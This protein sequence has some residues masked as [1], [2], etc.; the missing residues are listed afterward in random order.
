[1]AESVNSVDVVRDWDKMYKVFQNICIYS[2]LVTTKSSGLTTKE[3]EQFLTKFCETFAN[4]SITKNYSTLVQMGLYDEEK[5]LEDNTT[6][7]Q[8]WFFDQLETRHAIK[9]TNVAG[10][11]IGNIAN[12]FF[13]SENFWNLVT[14][15]MAAWVRGD[16]VITISETETGYVKDLTHEIVIDLSTYE[17]ACAVFGMTG[18]IEN[19]SEYN[20][21]QTALDQFTA[22]MVDSSKYIVN[23]F[24]SPDYEKCVFSSNSYFACIPVN[25]NDIPL[26]KNVDR[27]D[28]IY[29]EN[30]KVY[31]HTRMRVLKLQI[32]GVTRYNR[33]TNGSVDVV[34]AG[35]QLTGSN[36]LPFVEN[37][38]YN[39][40]Q[41]IQ[42]NIADLFL[43]KMQITKNDFPNDLISEPLTN[44]LKRCSGYDTGVIVIGVGGTDFDT[45]TEIKVFQLEYATL[46]LTLIKNDDGTFTITSDDG[47]YITQ[48]NITVDRTKTAPYS[49]GGG[50]QGWARPSW[51]ITPTNGKYTV[52]INNCVM[53]SESETLTLENYVP[54]EATKEAIENGTYDV[55][56]DGK[57]GGVGAIVKNLIDDP[58]SVTNPGEYLKNNNTYQTNTETGTVLNPTDTV[59]TE[60]EATKEAV[61]GDKEDNAG[62]P[63][64]NNVSVDTGFF[65]SYLVK[66]TELDALANVLWSD[67]ED[68]LTNLKKMFSDPMDACISLSMVPCLPTTGSRQNI[69]MG[70]FSTGVSAQ[71]ITKQFCQIDCGTVSF[72]DSL[73]G[74]ESYDGA[75]VMLYL[76]FIGMR[77]LSPAPMFLYNPI[78]L[79][80]NIDIVS[81]ACTAYVYSLSNENTWEIVATFGGNA[82]Q[83]IPLSSNA[84]GDIYR[85]VATIA[86]SA[87]SGGV[88]GGAA[89]AG[90]NA[91]ESAMNFTLPGPTHGGSLSGN[92]GFSGSMLPT[93]IYYHPIARDISDSASSV[94]G[95]PS[96]RSGKLSTC[97]GFTQVEKLKWGQ[98]GY[99]TY[100]EQQE[101]ES[102]LKEGVYF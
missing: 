20:K 96:M 51:T 9:Y 97:S 83:Q 85:S 32:S 98:I 46:P 31:A 94:N 21:V 62:L 49:A 23:L 68:I 72:A 13:I 93:A 26:I 69:K 74:Y 84:W 18:I 33:F 22:N 2:G 42:Y 102:L 39:T 34:E 4:Y 37:V 56:T 27:D 3:K 80:Y 16:F 61:Y 89:M 11:I 79:I 60:E 75:H 87:V 59:T 40:T 91:V 54:D 66:K 50:Y 1:M 70:F 43:R 28:S 7:L 35:T 44:D 53:S 15:V 6:D 90:S 17:S 38:I 47:G 24:V 100:E 67:A 78:K 57:T 92:L 77:E 30:G 99:M 82:A 86:A 76:P 73:T 88:E 71:R 55:I 14:P 29:F 95:Y 19:T 41:K 8:N 81:G 52:L 25:E 36:C 64:T 10:A 101:I 45:Y 63:I 48:H 65:T 12:Q 58:D 5:S